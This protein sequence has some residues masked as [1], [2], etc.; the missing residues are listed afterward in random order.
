LTSFNCLLCENSSNF[1]HQDNK[2]SYFRCNN[3]ELIFVPRNEQLSPKEEKSV[4]DLHQNIPDDPGYRKFLQ[5][6]VTPLNESIP[7]HSKGLDFGSGPGPTLHLMLAELGHSCLNYDIY[8]A[9][10]PELLVSGQ[11][12]FIASTEVVEHLSSPAVIFKQL[13]DLLKPGG[14]LAIM[15]KRSQNLERFKTWHYIQDP[16]HI[17]FYNE[18]NLQWI[19]NKYN[20]RVTFPHS[21]VAIFHTNH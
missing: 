19:A 11:Y 17:C 16:T 21:D 15:T 8:Y 13:F 12:D 6:F 10:L 9:H 4:Y 2:R 5:R 20:A 14:C 1:Y 7:R 3:C 18:F